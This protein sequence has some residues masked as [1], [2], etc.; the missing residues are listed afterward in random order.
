MVPSESRTFTF[1]GGRI[2]SGGLTFGQ[3]FQWNLISEVAPHDTHYIIPVEV[4][5]PESCSLD[6]ILACLSLITSK[7]EALR[8][9]YVIDA[10]GA[11]SQIVMGSG[12]H[13]VAIVDAGGADP[14]AAAELLKRRL[15]GVRIDLRA[16]PPLR[17]GVVMCGAQPQFLVLA[18]LHIVTDAWGI[19]ELEIE[20]SGLLTAKDLPPIASAG[21]AWQPY[22][23]WQYERSPPA[24][25]RHRRA[26][27]YA[28]GELRRFPA[29]MLAIP[30]HEPQPA[31]CWYG[32]LRSP[33]L[34]SAAARLATR[35]G[36]T[37]TSVILA[38]Y[39]LLLGRVSGQ[40][41][42]SIMLNYANRNSRNYGSIG[43]Y[44]Q[45]SPVR[46][47]LSADRLGDVAR[48]AHTAAFRA[49]RCAQYSHDRFRE[50]VKEVGEERGVSLNLLCAFN[51]L[52]GSDVRRSVTKHGS[53]AV[54]EGLNSSSTVEWIARDNNSHAGANLL[55]VPPNGLV[56]VADTRFLP[57]VQIE[58]LLRGIELLLNESVRHDGQLSE[59]VAA[60]GVLPPAHDDRWAYVDGSWI[61]L[62]NVRQLLRDAANSQDV[63]VTVTKSPNGDL[64][65]AARVGLKDSGLSPEHIRAR[66]GSLLSGR[67]A[68]MIPQQLVLCGA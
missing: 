38:A 68:V 26:L 57:P 59:V 53:L 10:D 42:S 23:E 22:D 65:L 56:L 19:S 30:P 35:Y 18:L 2:V 8:T 15:T 58:A 64:R 37:P 52:R 49:Y 5:V 67:E 41:T 1:S 48:T 54:D 20:L 66:A 4:P 47:E 29:A 17:I 28:R 31:R 55:V 62:D 32:R 3:K 63:G 21:S 12:E 45:S 39:S 40:G 43:P 44:M 13:E 11:P 25:R 51:S 60:T 33:T 9:H 46:I 34:G 24:M 50:I 27:E 36:V 6:H 14:A 61:N 7:H 16:K